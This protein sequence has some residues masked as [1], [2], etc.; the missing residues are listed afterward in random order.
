[1]PEATGPSLLQKASPTTRLAFQVFLHKKDET[2]G[3]MFVGLQDKSQREILRRD[4][5]KTMRQ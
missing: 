1:L 3:Q 5:K 4:S 2:L